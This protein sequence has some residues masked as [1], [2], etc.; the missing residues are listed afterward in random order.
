MNSLVTD[1][2]QTLTTDLWFTL[3]KSAA[4][5]CVVLGILLAVLFLIRRLFY[6]QSRNSGQG[7]IKMLATYSVAPKQRLLLLDVLGEKILVG[8]T[9]QSIP[10]IATLQDAGEVEIPNPALTSGFFKEIFQSAFKKQTQN[11]PT[12]GPS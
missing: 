7:L 9:P 12:A 8:I 4:M 10:R 1:P 3:I 6:Q 11:K 5:L 2:S